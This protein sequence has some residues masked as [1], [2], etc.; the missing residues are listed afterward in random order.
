MK[1][2]QNRKL[3]MQSIA[4]AAGVARSTV[5]FVLNNR[6]KERRISEKVE[7]KVREVAK[8]MN[9]QFNEVARTLRTGSS[10]IIA[11]VVADISDAF[12]ATLAYHFQEYAE[13]KG[14]MII[15]VSTDEK[16][17]R[18][19]T[20]FEMLSKR[21]V[22]GIIMVPVANIEDGI[23]EQL[24]PKIPM[25]F[26]DRYF[27][28][29]NTSRI[30]IDN[31]EISKM[32]VQLLIGKGCKR[33][34]FISYKDN[35]MHMQERKKGYIDALSAAGYNDE[36]LVCEVDYFNFKNDIIN[37]LNEKYKSSN[38]IDGI[39]IATGGLASV[40]I[41]YLV[42]IGIKL[43]SDIQL[44]GFDRIDIATG[45][46]IPYVKQPMAEICKSSFDILLNQINSKE[47]KPVDCRLSASIV[48]DVF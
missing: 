7:K 38:I 17:E 22:D 39:F 21:Q 46:S 47:S 42:N 32:A 44:I 43:Q 34:A 20:I 25:V 18:L 27:Q 24:N 35:L 45:I 13:E 31:Y 28:S 14:Y 16:E 10:H 29:F 1:D 37:F 9:Y 33:I 5:S 15:I 26:I 36:T 3:S 23:I 40:T 41:R 12:F 4:D 48:T 2:K 8:N 11:L 30:I 6:A 19:Y